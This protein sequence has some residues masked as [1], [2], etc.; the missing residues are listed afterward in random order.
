MLFVAD[1]AEWLR[2]A[3]SEEE[4]REGGVVVGVVAC[5]SLAGVLLGWREGGREEQQEEEASHVTQESASFSR[6]ISR[7]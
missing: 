1:V 6:N 7:S 2:Q 5:R 4:A 3:V